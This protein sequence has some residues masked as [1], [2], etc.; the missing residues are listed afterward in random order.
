MSS[1]KVKS[2]SETWAERYDDRDDVDLACERWSLRMAIREQAI[3]NPFKNSAMATE[4][5]T[6]SERPQAGKDEKPGR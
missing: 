4:G 5:G 6:E 3:A 2:L 1:D